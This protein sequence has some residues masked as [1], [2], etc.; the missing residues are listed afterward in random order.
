M[1]RD[2]FYQCTRSHR[3]QTVDKKLDSPDMGCLQLLSSAEGFGLDAL[4]GLRMFLG[5]TLQL[6]SVACLLI[7]RVFQGSSCH[8]PFEISH[9]ALQSIIAPTRCVIGRM[10]RDENGFQSVERMA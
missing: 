9:K 6:I 1:P 2:A 10:G 5:Q 7:N 4:D 3:I 8:K